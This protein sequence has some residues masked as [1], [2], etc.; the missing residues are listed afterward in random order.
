MQLRQ[1]P[2]Q[3]EKAMG[4]LLDVAP[5]PTY[6]PRAWLANFV[7]NTRAQL[8]FLTARGISCRSVRPAWR[9]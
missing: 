4:S 5:R 3:R 9:V 8:S 7:R 2:H 1:F 6:A